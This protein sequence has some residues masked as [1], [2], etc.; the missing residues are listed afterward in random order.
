LE[1]RARLRVRC[2]GDEEGDDEDRRRSH[3]NLLRLVAGA[4]TD[5]TSGFIPDC[6]VV[7]GQ[8]WLSQLLHPAAMDRF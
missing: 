7:R 4:S 3:A 5:N 2:R 8:V 1:R 6:M